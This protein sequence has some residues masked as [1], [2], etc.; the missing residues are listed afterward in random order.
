MSPELKNFYKAIQTWID[1]GCPE[2]NQHYFVIYVGL[3]NNLEWLGGE[4]IIE[5]CKLRWEMVEQFRAAGLSPAYP[6]GGHEELMK[7]KES[8]TIYSN[9]ARLAWIKEHAK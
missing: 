9:P 8:R 3:C 2:D 6:F 4:R 5:N 1:N 7:E